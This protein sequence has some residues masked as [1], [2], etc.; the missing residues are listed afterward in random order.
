MLLKAPIKQL[1]L[2]MPSK[3]IVLFL[4]SLLISLVACWLIAKLPVI[5]K[6]LLYLK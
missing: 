4:S 1:P 5:G 3:T 6:R 2:S